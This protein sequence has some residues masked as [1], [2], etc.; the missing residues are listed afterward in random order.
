VIGV[1]LCESPLQVETM[2]SG[3]EPTF[4]SRSLASGILH[5]PSAFDKRTRGV[6][7]SRTSGSVMHVMTA[8]WEGFGNG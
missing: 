8:A 1:S 7:C 2:S 3:D 5:F 4:S 6:R